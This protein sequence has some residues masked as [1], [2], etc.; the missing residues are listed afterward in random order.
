MK[1]QWW[2]A[3]AV[4]SAIAYGIG[5]MSTDQ[6]IKVSKYSSPSVTASYHFIGV[7]MFLLAIIIGLPF[8]LGKGAWKDLHRAFTTKDFWFVLA[9][10]IAFFVGDIASAQA[11]HTAPN[12]GYSVAIQDLY[13]I[14]TTLLPVLVFGAELGLRQSAGIVLALVALYLIA[15]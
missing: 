9:I 1:P 8:G 5:S 11:Y 3:L 2:L 6:L 15:Q 4:A 10:A 14:P 12:V 13:I 7:W